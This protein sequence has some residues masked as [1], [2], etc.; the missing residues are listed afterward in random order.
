MS[1][2]QRRQGQMPSVNLVP[3]LDVL[4]TVLTFFIIISMS[5]TGQQILN[6]TLPG[7]EAKTAAK[8]AQSSPTE[9]FVVGLDKEGELIVNN[10]SI[11]DEELEIKLLEFLTVN[12]QGQVVLK[13]EQSLDFRKISSVLKKLGKFGGSRV[14]LAVE[15]Q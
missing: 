3:M 11:S 9:E 6:V 1:W 8:L 14:S 13:A 4:M 15:S 5:L 7:L 2:R 12:P 10:Q